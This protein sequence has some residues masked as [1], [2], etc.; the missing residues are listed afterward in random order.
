MDVLTEIQEYNA[1]MNAL[2][3][4]DNIVK[5]TVVV[6]LGTGS[7][8]TEQVIV[9][10]LIHAFIEAR[11]NCYRVKGISHLE[12]TQKSFPPH[13]IAFSPWPGL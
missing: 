7:K 1:V 4:G 13:S 2:G 9:V 11:N 5:P 6:S 3:A 10:H 12:F 8:P